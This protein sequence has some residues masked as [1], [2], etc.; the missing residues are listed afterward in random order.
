MSL[1][2]IIH[3]I[4]LEALWLQEVLVERLQRLP[5]MVHGQSCFLMC[6]FKC[7]IG[8]SLAAGGAS[9]APAAAA[10]H[11]RGSAEGGTGRDRKAAAATTVFGRGR[12]ESEPPLISCFLCLCLS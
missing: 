7:V 3:N 4:L 2:V 11:G 12:G 9:G 1:Y 6:D 10:E 8:R 5:S